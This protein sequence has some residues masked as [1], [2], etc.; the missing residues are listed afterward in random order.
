MFSCFYGVKIKFHFTLIIFLLKSNKICS[1]AK[2]LI[3]KTLFKINKL[4]EFIS[5]SLTVIVELILIK[6]LLDHFK[7]AMDING[8][9]HCNFLITS[10]FLVHNYKEN[11][12]YS[13]LL[14]RLFTI[15]SL[16]VFNV[17]NTPKV[18]Q[19]V[20]DLIGEYS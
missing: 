8:K 7:F 14:Y 5:F 17:T 4:I 16:L 6:Y 1:G 19:P 11:I 10:L 12:I 2:S 9:S 3:I 15:I 20:N 13:F 18:L